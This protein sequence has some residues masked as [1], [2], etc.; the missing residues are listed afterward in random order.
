MG[1][2]LFPVCVS[3][4]TFLECSIGT[5]K[6]FYEFNN[7]SKTLVQN[8]SDNIKIVSVTSTQILGYHQH[9]YNFGF[10]YDRS[11]VEI[12]RLNGDISFSFMREPTKIEKDKCM[13]TRGWGCD[14]LYLLQHLN[15]SC[16]KSKQLF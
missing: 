1:A 15:G 5:N 3:A 16:K 8:S 11:M 4:T 13:K 2:I 10:D 6:Y 7:F 9:N 12:N 14:D